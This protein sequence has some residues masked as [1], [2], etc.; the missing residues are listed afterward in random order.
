M[1]SAG[2][3]ISFTY[4]KPWKKICFW[5]SNWNSVKNCLC[6]FKSTS[7][8]I[9]CLWPSSLALVLWNWSTVHISLVLVVFSRR[10]KNIYEQ[11]Y[12]LGIWIWSWICSAWK[13]TGEN[14]L[15]KL[16]WFFFVRKCISFWIICNKILN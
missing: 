14:K 16:K 5:S 12:M 2:T 8:G 9:C 6:S 11:L 1:S 10:R 13:Q 15:E 3:C 4:F 7:L